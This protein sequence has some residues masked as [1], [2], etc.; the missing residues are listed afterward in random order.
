MADKRNGSER[1]KTRRRTVRE[2]ESARCRLTEGRNEHVAA[3]PRST[4]HNVR[5]RVGTL[6]SR[7]MKG[8]S[9]RENERK[10]K[11]EGRGEEERERLERH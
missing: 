3:M 4:V 2:R 6:P 9:E 7:E 11:G 8:E 5:K 10:G 1:E